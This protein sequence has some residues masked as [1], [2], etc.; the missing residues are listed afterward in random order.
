MNIDN[1]LI[2]AATYGDV[3]ELESALGRGAYVNATDHMGLTALHHTSANGKIDATKVLLAKNAYVNAK[4]HKGWTPLHYATVCGKHYIMELLFTKNVDVNARDTTGHTALHW[5]VDKG[6]KKGIDMLR[7]KDADVNSLDNYGWT[8]LHKATS[9]GKQ[10][11]IELL[12]FHGADVNAKDNYGRVPLHLVA[13]DGTTEVAELFLAK[14]ADVNAKDNY[15]RSALHWTVVNDN[16]NVLQVLLTN[17]VDSC[18][19]DNDDKTAL[20]LAIE[21]NKADMAKLIAEKIKS[22]C[23]QDSLWQNELDAAKSKGYTDIVQI[24]E[25]AICKKSN[26]SDHESD[27]SAAFKDIKQEV[28]ELRSELAA[29][30]FKLTT[31]GESTLQAEAKD[32]PTL[33]QE[34]VT[35]RSTTVSILKVSGQEGRGEDSSWSFIQIKTEKATYTDTNLQAPETVDSTDPISNAA[36]VEKAINPF[37]AQILPSNDTVKF[38]FLGY[39]YRVA[40]RDHAIIWTEINSK[41]VNTDSRPF[42]SKCTENECIMLTEITLKALFEYLKILKTSIPFENVNTI[43]TSI[44]FSGRVFTGL[45]ISVLKPCPS[46]LTSSGSEIKICLEQR[47]DKS[48]T[49]VFEGF[50]KQATEF[51][52]VELNTLLPVTSSIASHADLDTV[53][54]A[55]KQTRFCAGYD[56]LKPQDIGHKMICGDYTPAQYEDFVVF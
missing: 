21:L 50:S 37:L 22:C 15:S 40:A 6:D 28:R 29:T 51:A 42:G 39:L 20:M 33:V 17:N 36:G 8:P 55:V 26:P 23:E 9:S 4:D 25:N 38:I 10:D 53:R 13:Y 11:I 7:K 14:G 44:Q 35:A 43:E 49:S 41:V 27:T 47:M 2:T 12:I 32:Q 19:R 3:Q 52:I 30:K 46:N 31:A 34:E 54:D 1:R 18:I 48:L 24:I 5:S 45:D 56:P 16:K